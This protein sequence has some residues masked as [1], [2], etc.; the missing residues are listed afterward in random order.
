MPMGL[1]EIEGKAAA[2]ALIAAPLTYLPC[3][4][5]RIKVE[6]YEER[7]QPDGTT[8]IV[9]ADLAQ[10]EGGKMYLEDEAGRTVSGGNDLAVGVRGP[11]S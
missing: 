4:G 11:A 10:V 8:Q 6:G 7:D 9:T 5:Y 2:D 1:V 3:C